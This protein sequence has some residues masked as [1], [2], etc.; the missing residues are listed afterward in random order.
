[1]M[2]TIRVITWYLLSGKNTLLSQLRKK[3]GNQ[4]DVIITVGPIDMVTLTVQIN[5][6]RRLLP[7]VCL[8]A[9]IQAK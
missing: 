5:M 8:H 4:Y 7:T 1:M 9:G 6:Q 3:P 2:D